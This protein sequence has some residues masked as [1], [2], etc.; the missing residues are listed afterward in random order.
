[1]SVEQGRNVGHREIRVAIGLVGDN[2]FGTNLKPTV[3]D[4]AFFEFSLSLLLLVLLLSDSDS[5]RLDACKLW[6]IGGGPRLRL[7]YLM[8]AC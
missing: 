6:L 3:E 2:R 4:S 7:R 5:T 8:I 1:M